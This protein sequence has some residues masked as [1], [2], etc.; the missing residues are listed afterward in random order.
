[1]VGEVVI[2]KLHLVQEITHD[3]P[4]SGKRKQ[5]IKAANTDSSTQDRKSKRISAKK[6]VIS[7]SANDKK[8]KKPVK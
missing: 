7:I 5:G 2:D 3:Y 8:G 1:M 4:T 6:A